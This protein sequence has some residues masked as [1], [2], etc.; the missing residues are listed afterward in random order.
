MSFSDQHYG[1]RGTEN[2]TG[3]V[4]AA[5]LYRVKSGKALLKTGI[6]LLSTVLKEAKGQSH[7]NI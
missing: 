2:A 4:E 3:G 6:I 1:I 7:V 5:I